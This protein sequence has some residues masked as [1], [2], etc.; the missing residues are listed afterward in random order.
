MKKGEILLVAFMLLI[1]VISDSFI[2][3]GSRTI[4]K[5]CKLHGAHIDNNWLWFECVDGEKFPYI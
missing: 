1:V 5:E 2:V 3:Y 4:S